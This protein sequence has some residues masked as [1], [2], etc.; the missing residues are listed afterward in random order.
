[1]NL[2]NKL[3]PIFFLISFSIGLFLVYIFGP[4]PTVL[5]EFPD[6]NN[7][8]ILYEDDAHNC[9][10]YKSNKI[11]CPNDKSKINTIPLQ[12]YKKTN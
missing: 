2:F 1:M 5:Y 12:F 8:N 4:R 6:P 7:E 9:Y 3:D 10:R 11:A